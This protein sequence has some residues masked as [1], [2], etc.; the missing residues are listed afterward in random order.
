MEMRNAELLLYT[1]CVNVLVK[2]AQ[3]PFVKTYDLESLVNKKD[4]IFLALIEG[5]HLNPGNGYMLKKRNCRL[6][7]PALNTIIE[8]S[9]QYLE[10]CT[11]QYQLQQISVVISN[12][13]YL[14]YQQI[15]D[16][17]AFGNLKQRLLE[18]QIIALKLKMIDP[19]QEANL[20]SLRE[21]INEYTQELDDLDRKLD[22]TKVERWQKFSVGGVGFD[23]SKSPNYSKKP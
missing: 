14:N 12:L 11:D 4:E 15:K 21:I 2:Y 19:N 8:N 1:E 7:D 22:P 20:S 9:T 10:N 18:Q 13:E 3:S 6:S 5:G 23:F 17:P 16:N